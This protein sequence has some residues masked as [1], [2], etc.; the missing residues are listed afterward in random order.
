LAFLDS[1]LLF[2]FFFLLRLLSPIV[3]L[4]VR[5]PNEQLLLFVVAALLP[6]FSPGRTK[7]EAKKL[8]GHRRFFHGL[9]PF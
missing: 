4:S 9:L 8:F 2:L 7:R 1:I 6:S 3:C 5:S